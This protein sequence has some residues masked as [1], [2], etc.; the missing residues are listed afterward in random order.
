MGGGQKSILGRPLAFQG[1]LPWGNSRDGLGG[2]VMIGWF[3]KRGRS[4][5]VTAK[6]EALF[7]FD[8]EHKV[9]PARTIAKRIAA[10]YGVGPTHSLVDEISQAIED[11]W[12]IGEKRAAHLARVS[13][14]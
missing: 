5:T 2:G 9:E 12:A 3:G 11:A 14:P 4:V 1:M 13:A 8:A 7:A 6:D 10:K